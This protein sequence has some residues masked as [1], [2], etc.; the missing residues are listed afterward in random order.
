MGCGEE[1]GAGLCGTDLSLTFRT[2]PMDRAAV[3]LRMADTQGH[4]EPVM[5][6]CFFMRRQNGGRARRRRETRVQG[7]F[8]DGGGIWRGEV[9]A[10]LNERSGG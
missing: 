7:G 2:R 9:S 3:P 5:P 1:F 6:L 10:A 8:A 4:A